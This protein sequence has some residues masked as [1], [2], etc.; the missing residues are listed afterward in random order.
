MLPRKFWL[1]KCKFWGEL[2]GGQSVNGLDTCKH[3]IQKYCY[4][5]MTS[6]SR[7]FKND[8]IPV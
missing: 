7:L 3:K 5:E 6:Q 4:C 1:E 8:V 2:S